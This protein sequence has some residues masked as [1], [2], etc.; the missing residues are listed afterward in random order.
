MCLVISSWS[1]LEMPV[2]LEEDGLV[3]GNRNMVK[4]GELELAMVM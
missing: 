2:N 4:D 3:A 1:E